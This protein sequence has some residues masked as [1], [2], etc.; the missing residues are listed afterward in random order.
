MVIPT[1]L[2]PIISALAVCA[3]VIPAALAAENI[4]V[5]AAA[6]LKNALDELADDYPD[7]NLQIAYGGS[8]TLSRQILQGAPAQ[9]FISANLTWMDLLEQD[10]ILADNSRVDLL[11]NR[12][13][14]IAA[15][16]STATLFPAPGFELA[17]A[18]G[19]GLLAMALVKAVPAG[20]YG[21]QAL[22]SLDAWDSL[23][24]K[25]VQTD[26]VRAALRLVATGEAPMGIVYATDLGASPNV[27]L[28]GLFPADSHR[29]IHYPM[30]LIDPVTPASRDV[31]DYLNSNA[32]RAVFSRHGFIPPK[33]QQ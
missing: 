9:L 2:R 15:P 26:N 14:L 20:I 5:F 28:L 13:A 18:L 25:I 23:Q 30:A 27:Q 7:G 24:G 3:T 17:A 16:N 1:L 29:P 22:E 33:A 32:A 31:Y 10:G 6:S 12:L 19:D 8:S 21:Q 4:T 11:G